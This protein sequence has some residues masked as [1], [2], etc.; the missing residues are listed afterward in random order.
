M[1]IIPGK[2]VRPSPILIY[3]M[4]TTITV[5]NII[6]SK[7]EV[8]RQISEVCMMVNTAAQNV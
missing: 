1:P 5:Y 2:T 3:I 8:N 4:L 6:E 7:Y